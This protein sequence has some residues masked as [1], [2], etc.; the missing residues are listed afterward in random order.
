MHIMTY[1][2]VNNRAKPCVHN[3]YTSVLLNNSRKDSLGPVAY[4]L[5]AHKTEIMRLFA[6]DD[7][8][9]IIQTTIIYGKVLPVI[10]LFEMYMFCIRVLL[11]RMK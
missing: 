8:I 4:I 9:M 3:G 5:S 1:S 7:E 2:F 10:I 11:C 6:S